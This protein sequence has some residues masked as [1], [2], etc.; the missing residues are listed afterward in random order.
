MF[1]FLHKYEDAASKFDKR[2]HNEYKEG[3]KEHNV[4]I[5]KNN[6]F[7]S[8]VLLTIFE[9]ASCFDHFS[10][11]KIISTL[12]ADLSCRLSIVSL[13]TVNVCE[14]ESEAFCFMTRSLFLLHS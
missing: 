8:F 12:S 13:T 1:V 7:E 4:F 3:H 6:F 5:L 10:L 9:T 2:E 14:A 11:V